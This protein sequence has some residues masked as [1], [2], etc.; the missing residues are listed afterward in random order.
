[1]ELENVVIFA[2]GV[3]VGSIVTSKLLGHQPVEVVHVI[4][5]KIVP[6]KKQEFEEEFFDDNEEVAE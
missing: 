3:V 4:K 2:A 1:M 6:T 5:A